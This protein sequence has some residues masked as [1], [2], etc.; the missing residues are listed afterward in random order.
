MQKGARLSFLLSIGEVAVYLEL[1][2]GDG[3]IFDL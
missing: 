3:R 1:Y 2:G